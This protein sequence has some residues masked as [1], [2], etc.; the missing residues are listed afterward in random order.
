MSNVTSIIPKSATARDIITSINEWALHGHVDEILSLWWVLT[1]LRGPDVP[2]ENHLKESTTEIIRASTL[3][4]V[5]QRIGMDYAGVLQKLDLH[6]RLHKLQH[7]YTLH[8]AS[9]RTLTHFEGHINLA[10]RALLR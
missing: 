8:Y 1:A 2:D 9:S 6:T 3:P 7:E 4:H 5:M 10:A